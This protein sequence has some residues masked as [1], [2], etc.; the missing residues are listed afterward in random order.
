MMPEFVDIYER[1]GEEFKLP[2]MLMKDYATFSVMEYSGSGD[3]NG[4]RCR[5]SPGRATRQSD[6][7]SLGRDAVDLAK[8]TRRWIPIALRE[9]AGRTELVGSSF[10]CRYRHTSY[11]R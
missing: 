9:L 4:I 5:A 7:R 11:G 2:L 6:R 3:F 10:Q 8:W 1:L